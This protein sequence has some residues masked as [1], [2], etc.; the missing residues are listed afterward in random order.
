MQLS[1]LVLRATEP[2]RLAAFYEALG[3]KFHKERHGRGPEHVSAALG[4]GVLEIY[5]L[6]SGQ[7]A[8]T[9][10]RIGFSVED[11]EIACR[12]A[13]SAWGEVVISPKATEWGRQATLRDPA[14][15]LVDLVQA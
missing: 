10:L 1:H 4:G 7:Q 3:L 11:L 5:P 9:G 6:S 2:L 12:S 8:T 14:G 13:Q 15:H